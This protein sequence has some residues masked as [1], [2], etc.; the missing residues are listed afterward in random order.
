MHNDKPLWADIGMIHSHP[1]YR[2]TYEWEYLSDSFCIPEA[3]LQLIGLEFKDEH[4]DVYSF[5]MLL[6]AMATKVSTRWDVPLEWG[7]VTS[8]FFLDGKRLEGA[9][10]QLIQP[11]AQLP[12]GPA[13]DLGELI[14]EMVQPTERLLTMNTVLER[15]RGILE[16][17]V[18]ETC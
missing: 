13:W 8:R 2:D 15:L 3:M 16:P 1:N 10:K 6:L 11:L 7:M 4:H 5:G 17:F 18:D 9:D 12:D 14:L